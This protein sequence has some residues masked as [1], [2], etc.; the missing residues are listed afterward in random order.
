MTPTRQKAVTAYRAQFGQPPRFV[1]RAPG[2]LNLIG[3]LTDYNHGFVLPMAIERSVWMAFTPREDAVVRL[4]STTFDA[5]ISFSLA[6]LSK[7]VGWQE[8]IKGVA[9]AYAEAGLPPRGFDAAIAGNVPRGAGLS[10][11]AALEMAAALT[12]TTAAGHPWDAV[13]AARMCTLAENEWVGVNSGIM[14][15]LIAG[16]GQKGH[17]LLIDCRTVETT[18]VPLPAELAPVILDTGTRRSLAHSEFNTRRAECEAAA[19][20]LGVPYLRDA[21]PEEVEAHRNT[22]PTALYKRARHITTENR[23]VKA[24][25][26]ALQNANPTRLGQLMTA[27]HRSLSRD[28]EVSSP[29]LDAMVTCALDHPA[30]YGACLTGAGFAGC[31]VAVVQRAGVAAFIE[32]V[33]ACYKAETGYTP[34]LAVSQPSQGASLDSTP[35]HNDLQ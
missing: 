9:W 23:R 35:A 12:V 30:C 24:A 31:C 13:E 1:S 5:R 6:Y 29:A 8:Y 16:L 14:D 25:F 11:S 20:R 26:H 18:P 34:T 28:F 4:Y 2:R 27:S 3:G 32:E 19:A 15:Q 21:T 33:S 22:L 17:A 7:N 10:S